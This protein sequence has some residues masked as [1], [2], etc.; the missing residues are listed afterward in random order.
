MVDWLRF[1]V[2]DSKNWYSQLFSLD[3]GCINGLCGRWLM[4]TLLFSCLHAGKS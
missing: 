3:T 1:P 4:I 2:K